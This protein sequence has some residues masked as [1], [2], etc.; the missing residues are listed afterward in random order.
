MQ[1]IEQ[2][3]KKLLSDNETLVK[4]NQRLRALIKELDKKIRELEEEGK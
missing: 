2:E 3:L 1:M 4:E